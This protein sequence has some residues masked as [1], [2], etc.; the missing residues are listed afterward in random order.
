MLNVVD[1]YTG[2]WAQ[3]I[4]NAMA[5]GKPVYFPDG[6]YSVNS[7]ITLNSHAHFFGPGHITLNAPLTGSPGML[8][9]ATDAFNITLDGLKLS[10]TSTVLPV[11]E[12]LLQFNGCSKLN[13]SNVNIL[14]ARKWALQFIGCT[15]SAICNSTAFN[16]DGSAIVLDNCN[17][18]VL[19]GNEIGDNNSFGIYVING[20]TRCSFV[21]NRT[22]ANGLEL[23][24]I[25]YG[26][27]KNLVMGNHAQG[28]G[29]NG[30]SITSRFCRVIGN[31]CE[32]N[33]HSGIGIYGENNLVANNVLLSNVSRH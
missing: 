4:T 3:A 21:G 33:L 5:E 19:T 13:I 10:F 28:T 1:F 7:T 24:G 30:I 23:I 27:D 17:K 22:E 15:E 16:S 9:K 32:G 26:C 29:D 18:L 20:T 6:T 8:F 11:F 31:H 12:A 25:T 14:N 2:N